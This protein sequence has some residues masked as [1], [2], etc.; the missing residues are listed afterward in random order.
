[1][2][3]NSIIHKGKDIFSKYKYALIVLVIGLILL[4]IPEK[5][6][7]KAEQVLPQQEL[8]FQIDADALSQIL[9]TVEGAGRV[10]VM[11]SVATGE[12]TVFQANSD[13]SETGENKSI[14][15][16]TVII[17]DSGKNESGLITQVNPPTYKGTIVVCQG[18]DSPTVRLAIMQAVSRI[19]GLGSD[20]ICVLKMK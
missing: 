16:E 8:H 7:S 15:T 2:E 3:I 10:Q 17:T 5:T 14:K 6:E 19:T 11:L 18:A 20:N 13:Q 1:M 9:Q 12:K 4:I